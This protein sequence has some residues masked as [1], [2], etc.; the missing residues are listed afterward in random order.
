M[1]LLYLYFRYLALR[2]SPW[3]VLN[4]YPKLSNDRVNKKRNAREKR[5]KELID[6][7]LVIVS[8]KKKLGF[9]L[10]SKYL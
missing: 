8:A 3:W 6:K 1:G 7:L 4:I 5:R 10:V 9:W 2:V